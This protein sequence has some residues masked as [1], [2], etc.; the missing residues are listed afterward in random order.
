MPH[1]LSIFEGINILPPGHMLIYEPSHGLKIHRYWSPD[2]S[3]VDEIINLPEEEIIEHLLH[4]LRQGV[5]RRLM[6]DVPIGFFP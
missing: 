4:L 1:P 6:S 2:F 5:K 3:P